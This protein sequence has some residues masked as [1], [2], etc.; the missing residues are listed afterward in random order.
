MP[1]TEFDSLT[2]YHL[3]ARS[4]VESE[5]QPSKL[6]VGGSSPSGQTNALQG[7]NMQTFL[8][9][10]DFRKSLECL[11][12]KRL[13]NQVY[14]EG[15]TLLRGGWE[16]HPAKRMWDGY[17]AALAQ[18]CYVGL[19][20]LADRGLYY[21]HHRPELLA[22]MQGITIVYPPW[23]GNSQFH[24]SHRSNL[25]RKD[26]HWYGQFGWKEPPDLEYVWP[27]KAGLM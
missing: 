25:L 27:T 18:Y 7:C 11:D 20:V 13:G 22:K 9:Y 6:W 24:A 8:P 26:P 19:D 16:N 3:S 4:S 12:P 1:Q 14:R 23:L 2:A 17:T 15:L 10:P 21:D 5:Q